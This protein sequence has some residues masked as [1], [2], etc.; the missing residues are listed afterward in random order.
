VRWAS[1]EEP[2]GRAAR[3]RIARAMFNWAR[4]VGLV[5]NADRQVVRE[6]AEL[7]AEVGDHGGA[8]ECWELVGD[9]L[10][11]AEAYQRAGELERLEAVLAREEVRR[12]RTHRVTDAFEEYKLHLRSGERDLA[13]AALAIC[14]E[15]SSGAPGDGLDQGGYRRLHE[16]LES[17]LL[18]DGVVTVR[19]GSRTTTWVGAF[20]FALG[21]EA[22]CQVALRDAGISRRHCEILHLP[23]FAL[24]DLDSKNGTF[25]GGVRLASGGTL[26]LDGEGEMGVGDHCAL[27][28]TV[29]GDVLSLE[30]SRGLDRGLRVIASSKPMPIFGR[31]ELRFVDGRPRLTAIAG[32]PLHLA[33]VQTAGAVQLIRGDLVELG[34]EKLEVL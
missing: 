18:R 6:A 9:E 8:G 12:K 13:L 21:R 11:A 28:F 30:V 31:A 7:F 4:Q 22:T 3:R 32:Q 33:G 5:S 34:G 25:L 16:E 20:P 29:T 1:P 27:R 19:H 10:Q 26:N 2:D 24:R 23:G 17:R 15:S 14:L